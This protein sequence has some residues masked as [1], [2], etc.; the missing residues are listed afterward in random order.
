M[1]AGTCR[2]AFRP[3]RA[4]TAALAVHAA[5][6]VTTETIRAVLEH[7]SQVVESAQAVF[8]ADHAHEHGSHQAVD[9]RGAGLCCQQTTIGGHRGECQAH[10]L[11]GELRVT[12]DELDDQLHAL[13][14]LFR[15]TFLDARDER[16]QFLVRARSQLGTEQ[17]LG[18]DVERR[19]ACLRQ[20]VI[21]VQFDRAG[22]FAHD[23]LGS[24]VVIGT[25][26]LVNEDLDFG[27]PLE[28]AARVADDRDL[29]AGH[30]QLES[31]VGTT[32]QNQDRLARTGA[33]SQVPDD[34]ASAQR[35]DRGCDGNLLHVSLQSDSV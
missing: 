13:Q 8:A 5:T 19:I 7:G 12:E 35:T 10:L 16:V 30:R 31:V 28:R 1:H 14:L 32:V 6:R 17:V 18:V 24:D 3:A 15:T 22:A 25:A 11:F 21:P 20:A 2:A 26:I 9:T 33:A 34:I 23:G 29:V 27:V 4:V